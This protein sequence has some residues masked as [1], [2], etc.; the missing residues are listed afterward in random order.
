M[1]EKPDTR[2]PDI[3]SIEKKLRE[4][5]ESLSHENREDQRVEESADSPVARDPEELLSHQANESD[6]TLGKTMESE[7]ESED[8]ATLVRE[9][10]DAAAEELERVARRER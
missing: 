7:D 2:T 1:S 10:K 5:A 8:A 9:G 4:D 6:A 3:R